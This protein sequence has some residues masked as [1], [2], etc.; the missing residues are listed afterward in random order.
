M[1]HGITGFSGA[2]TFLSPSMRCFCGLF[3]ALVVEICFADAELKS[4]I[5]VGPIA[6]VWLA[7]FDF[8]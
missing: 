4:L 2:A 3:L 8:P 1:F 7:E 5:I 6:D